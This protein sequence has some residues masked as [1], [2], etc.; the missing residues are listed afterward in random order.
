[1]FPV[2]PF[3]FAL[4]FSAFVGHSGDYPARIVAANFKAFSHFQVFRV[5]QNILGQ[6][7]GN[8]AIPA[9]RAARQDLS[10]PVAAFVLD[11]MNW[12]H[13]PAGIPENLDNPLRGLARFIELSISARI[14]VGRI[15]Y[16]LFEELLAMISPHHPSFNGKAD[17][18]LKC[19]TSV[20]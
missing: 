19:N 7:V 20:E 14:F 10:D 17:S 5:F 18:S 12:R 15:E 8:D 13:K 2:L 1:M 6:L 11:A 16:G 3:Q 4:L 9:C